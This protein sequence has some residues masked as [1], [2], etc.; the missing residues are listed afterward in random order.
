MSS[1]SDR[2]FRFKQF[3][4]TDKA[5]AMKIGMDAVLLGAYSGRLNFKT[6]LDIGCG[7]GILSLMLAQEGQG[8]VYAIDVDENAAAEASLNFQNSPWNDQLLSEKISVQDFVEKSDQKFD[9]IICNPPYF[10]NSLKSTTKGR[11]I[12]RHS[13][14]LSFTDLSNAVAR[15]ISIDGHF[16]VIIPFDSAEKMEKHMLDEGLNLQS[17][18]LIRNREGEKPIRIIQRYSKGEQMGLKC[19]SLV[20]FDYN[21]DYSDHFVAL[22]RHYYYNF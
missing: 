7:C 1:D 12:A 9:K 20:I 16:D 17:Q 4:L 2:I 11:N 10:Q 6:A 3:S 18:L 8:S 19:S 22:T 15:L 5:S 14:S 13:E 21:G